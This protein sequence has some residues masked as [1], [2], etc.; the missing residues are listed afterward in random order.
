MLFIMM[1]LNNDS[2]NLVKILMVISD[3][4]VNILY[5]I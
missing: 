1:S 2:I 3:K 5:L 4:T